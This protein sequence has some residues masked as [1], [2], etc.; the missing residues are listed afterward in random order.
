MAVSPLEDFSKGT[1]QR[2]LP[3]EQIAEGD[4]TRV[5]LCSGK[6]Y[7]ELLE[8]REKADRHDLAL[9]RLEQLYPVPEEQ[10][11]A[12]LARHPDG[13]PVVWV[14]EEPENMGAWYFLRAQY[15][16][17]LFGRYPF[18]GVTRPPS[19]S[20]ATGSGSS[21][22]SEQQELIQKALDST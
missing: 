9:V 15:C 12:V 22:R 20:P 8:A 7:Y 1:Y 10:L 3:D 13:T 19:A 4:V 14:Q 16:D 17:S 5:L 21:H 6:I 2:V 18:F 11:A